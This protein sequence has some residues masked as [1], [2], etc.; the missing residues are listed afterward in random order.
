MSPYSAPTPTQ[1]GRVSSSGTKRAVC[2][3]PIVSAHCALSTDRC[4]MMNIVF[5][6]AG[7]RGRHLAVARWRNTY[8]IP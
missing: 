1:T 2:S 5:I 6:V 7:A 8:L 4:E 3:C